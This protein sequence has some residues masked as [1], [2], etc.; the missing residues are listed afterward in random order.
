MW[1]G[2]LIRVRSKH[3]GGAYQVAYI[4]AVSESNEAI[5]LVRKK[6]AAADDVVED[7]GHVSQELLNS[8]HL[9]PGAFMP[10]GDKH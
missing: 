8:L 7:L 2:R 10:M 1:G 6:A 9:E 3:R 5:E 4:V